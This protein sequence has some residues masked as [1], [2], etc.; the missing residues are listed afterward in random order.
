MEENG[1]APPSTKMDISSPRYK[2]SPR[3]LKIPQPLATRYKKKFRPTKKIFV[4]QN[5]NLTQ[6]PTI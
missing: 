3:S 1:L 5:D 2:R 4:A 6:V